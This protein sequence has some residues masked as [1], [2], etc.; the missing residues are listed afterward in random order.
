MDADF[1]RD[2]AAKG[3]HAK[4][5]RRQAAL[6]ARAADMPR[7]DSVENAKGRLEIINDLVVSGLLA[8]S[9]AGAAVRAVE[10]W[11]KAEA[12]ALDLHRIKEMERTI[13]DLENEL[14]R[15]RLRVL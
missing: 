15:A 5:A 4:E 8:G 9:Q 13:T 12:H 10:V 14:K 1:K 11:L 3:G 7:L 6:A 2:R